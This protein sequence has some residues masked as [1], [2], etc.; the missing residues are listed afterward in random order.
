MSDIPRIR[1]E[2]VRLKEILK[3]RAGSSSP[4]DIGQYRLLFRRS[5]DEELTFDEGRI[6]LNEKDV[7]EWVEEAADGKRI[8]VALCSGLLGVVDE[9]R[10]H[11]W[12]KYGTD[13]RDFNA[14]AQGLLEGLMT[15]LGSAYD[16]MSGGIRVQLFGGKLWIN[17]IDPKVVLVL[18]LSNPTQERRRYLESIQTKLALILEGKAGKSSSHGVME[19]A[20][21]IYHQIFEALENESASRPPLLLAAVNDLGRS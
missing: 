18:F 11:V 13:N 3:D 16:Q 7:M 6:K 17:D 4:E 5:P 15:R 10:R 8:D 1:R 20:K 2:R 21:R 12:S 19:E 9:Y 14:Q